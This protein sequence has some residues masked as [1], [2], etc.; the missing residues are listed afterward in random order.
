MAELNKAG[1]QHVFEMVSFINRLVLSVFLMV[2]HVF[3]VIFLRPVLYCVALYHLIVSAV[4]EKRCSLSAS[5]SAI[6]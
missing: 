4:G 2:F 6:Y 5:Q 3:C 1:L